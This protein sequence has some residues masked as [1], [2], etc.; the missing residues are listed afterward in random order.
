M[1]TK[2]FIKVKTFAGKHVHLKYSD[3]HGKIGFH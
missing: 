1:W 2:T 3:F